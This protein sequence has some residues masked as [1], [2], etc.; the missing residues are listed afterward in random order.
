MKTIFALAGVIFCF[1]LFCYFTSEVKEF[2]GKVLGTHD[3][4]NY[5]IVSVETSE[6]GLIIECYDYKFWNLKK[7]SPE[8]SVVVIERKGLFINELK[9]RK[10]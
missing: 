3:Y 2:D 10:K 4:P 1:A 9:I 6:K 5:Q 7:L 8:D